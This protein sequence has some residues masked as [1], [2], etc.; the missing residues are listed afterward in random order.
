VAP[1]DA[2]K[3]TSHRGRRPPPSSPGA[4][5]TGKANPRTNTQPEIRVRSALHARGLRFR[6]DLPIE[7]G[8]F[9]VRPDI[10]FSRHRVAVF[11][12]GCFWHR[13][14]E[15]AVLPKANRDYWEPKL[16]RNVERDREADRALLRGGWRVL[17]IWEHVPPEQAVAQ[18]ERAL[19]Q[20]HPTPLS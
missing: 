4:S 8:G 17:R 20:S 14:P 15:H 11:V 9:R 16:S 7:L 1:C 6:K 19:D 18:I 10:V 13:C 2:V 5:A 12:D 3:V